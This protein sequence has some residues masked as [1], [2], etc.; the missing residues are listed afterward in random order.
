MIKNIEIKNP[1]YQNVTCCNEWLLYEN[2]YEWLHSQGNFDK[3]LSGNGWDIDKDILVKGNKV[4]SSETCCLVP[5]NINKL[6][7]KNDVIRGILP[8]GVSRDRGK[9]RALCNNPFTKEYEYLGE[10]ETP[11]D[12]FYLGYKPYKENII[13][14]VAQIEYDKGN[15]TEICYN[16][17]MN[18]EV[19][20]TD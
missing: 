11:E 16:A 6:F 13:K 1:S 2:F 10:Y 8:L 15:I 9:F 4:Y 17:M 14:K 5:Q 20:I 18:Y 12:A 3:W 19:E 7:I